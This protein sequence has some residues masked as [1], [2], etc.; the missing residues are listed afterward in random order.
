M[1]H[2]MTRMNLEDIMLSEKNWTQK[3]NHHMFPLIWNIQMGKVIE[4]ESILAVTRGCREWDMGGHSFTGTEI[5]FGAIKKFW[6]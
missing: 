3:D 1:L 6:I 2:A 4:T 5:L